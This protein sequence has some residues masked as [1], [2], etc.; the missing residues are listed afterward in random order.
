MKKR[1]R[2]IAW[3]LVLNMGIAVFSEPV[4]AKEP[5]NTD[6]QTESV[7]ETEG[8]ADELQKE[9]A[10]T[11]GV[12]EQDTKQSGNPADDQAGREPDEAQ[13]S[14]GSVT[15][16]TT[17]TDS[18][19]DEKADESED[20]NLSDEISDPDFD[21]PG[22]GRLGGYDV[23]GEF[24][25]NSVKTRAAAGA[26]KHNSKFNGYT[27]TQGI[28]VSKWNNTIN[29]TSVK[30]SGIEFAFIRTSYRGT[31]TGKLAKDPT[32]ATNLK[33]ASAAGV[34][35]GAYIFSQAITTTEAEEEADYLLSTVK[36]YNITMPLVFDFEYYEGGRLSKAKLSKRKQTDIC[37]A[38]CD[39]IKAAGY[40]PLVYA[41]KSMLTSDLYASEITAN[42]PVWLAHYTTSTDYAGDY[43][44]WQYS[45]TGTVSGISGNVDM[46]FW[47]TKPGS[48]SSF[49]SGSAT[50]QL[51][52][53]AVPVLTGKATAYDKVKLS[54]KKISGASGY[55]LYRYNSSSKKYVKIKTITSGSTVSYTDTGRTMATTYKYKIK[56]YV[57]SGEQT[58]N[59]AASKEV[60]VKTDSTMTGKVNGSSVAVRSGPSASKK[61]I[62]TVGRNTG[63]TITGTSGSW[64]KIS[65][66]VGGK[67]KTG[68]IKK[69]YVTIIRK[70]T[71]KAS[72]ASA[73]KIKLSWNKISGASGYVVQRYNSSKKKYVT[74]KTI[75]K[76]ST[77][78]YTNSGL[79][80]NTTYKYRIRS[81]KTVKG[82]KIYSYY[83]S[84]KSAKTSK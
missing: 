45:S 40:T 29:W 73:S 61:K 31:E 49:G 15:D 23:P 8:A 59:S 24:Y 22:R 70:P 13:Q 72:A 76:G 25:G 9:N 77:T 71:L 37:L 4:L 34:K 83:C 2:L 75:K 55:I 47:Y 18:V 28:D 12:D 64:Y 68:Y 41:N 66:K 57:T 43:D 17:D 60:S 14:E 36:G 20:E 3:L 6:V 44:F 48:T 35:I 46:N 69:S 30:K 67:T 39:R 7:A 80:K 51:T 81:Y 53:P 82:H 58:V 65:I 32:A 33:N 56:S 16:K 62:K 19:Q 79:K 84:A 26:I 38:F 42:Y 52:A 63:I 54:W 21:D 1:Q 5:A 10:Q 74:V 78:S 11:T 27:I 50:T